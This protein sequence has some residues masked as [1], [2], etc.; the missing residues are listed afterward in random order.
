MRVRPGLYAGKAEGPHSVVCQLAR[1]RGIRPLAN[2]NHEHR[3]RLRSALKLWTHHDWG[4]KQIRT[5]RRTVWARVF[6]QRWR[7]V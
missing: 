4:A 2:G 6:C 7:C 3:G 1:R 5:P